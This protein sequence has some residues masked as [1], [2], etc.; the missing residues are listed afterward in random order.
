[1]WEELFNNEV[2]VCLIRILLSLV[3]GFSIGFERKVRSK[4]AGIRTH[5]IVSVGACLFMVISIYGFEGD[6]DSARVAAQIVSGIGF[7]GAG[8]I[9]YHKQMLRGLT[10][11]AGIWTTAAIGM[12]CGAGMY[13]VSCAVTALIILFQLLMH[14]KIKLFRTKHYLS[15]NI[16]YKVI[17]G[18]EG[19]KIKKIFNINSFSKILAKNTNDGLI[20]NVVINTDYV[21][22]YNQINDILKDNPYIL[23]IEREDNEY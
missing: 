6:Y 11:A 20:Y 13:V 4:E 19:E 3:L 15:I 14:T 7:L 21:I 5:S 16:V 22:T 12:A 17:D 2:L 8:M 9:F 18:D 1:M 23:S 10:T